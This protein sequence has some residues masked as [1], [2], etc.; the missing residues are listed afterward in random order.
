MQGCLICSP[1]GSVPKEGF[2][3]GPEIT[4]SWALRRFLERQR[5]NI[6]QEIGLAAET[7]A[8]SLGLLLLDERSRGVSGDG[9][10]KSW[11]HLKVALL[12][13]PVGGHP[14]TLTI[15]SSFSPPRFPK[16]GLREVVPSSH[17]GKREDPCTSWVYRAFAMCFSHRTGSISLF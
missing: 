11:A 5:T 10:M 9:S 8:C 13:I 12:V 3:K 16:I 17:L 6:P 4:E 2:P 7:T 15:E 1:L 14:A